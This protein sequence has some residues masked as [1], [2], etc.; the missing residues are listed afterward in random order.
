LTGSNADEIEDDGGIQNDN[1]K[2]KESRNLIRDLFD[3][4]GFL[5]LS[6]EISLEQ[7][8][9]TLE[10]ELDG[11]YHTKF[12]T[13]DLDIGILDSFWNQRRRDYPNLYEVYMLISSVPG[14][15]VSVERLFSHLKFIVAD[16]RSRL[17]GSILDSILFVR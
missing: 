11:F 2:D 10:E 9:R 3:D 16:Q 13:M 7:L 17:G 14:T 6:N 1:N 4:G 12:G 15:Q 8:E 5:S